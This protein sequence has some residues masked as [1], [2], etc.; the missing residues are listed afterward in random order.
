MVDRSI[1]LDAALDVQIPA[2]DEGSRNF[3]GL[4][5][6]A[7]EDARPLRPG[8]FVRAELQLAPL[9]ETL[10]VPPDAVRVTDAGP[11]VVRAVAPPDGGPGGGPALVAEWVP[12]RLLGSDPEGSAVESL[13]PALAAGDRVVVTGVDLAAP[14]TPLM[15]RDPGAPPAPSEEGE[16]GS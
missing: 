6:L 2:A 1:A 7:G 12:V 10:V 5:R 11:I 15:A 13:G 3:R 9:P 16:R 8:T 4:V 14:Q